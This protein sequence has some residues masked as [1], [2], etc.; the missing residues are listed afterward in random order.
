VLDALMLNRITDV[1]MIIPV[2]T[3][4]KALPLIRFLPGLDS[5]KL[6]LPDFKSCCYNI[7]MPI[8]TPK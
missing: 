7:A 5:W 6:A 4:I 8:S 2:T 3:I 1:V